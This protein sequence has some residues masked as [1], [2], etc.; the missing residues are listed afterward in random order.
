MKFFQSLKQR[1]T[2][3]DHK[4][5][6][7]PM[8]PPDP[9]PAELIVPEV[10]VAEL[11]SALAGGQPPLLLDVREPYEW[12]QVR[13]P[14]ALHMPMN[15]VPARL[16]ELPKAATII[17]FCAH[18]S[19]SYGVA[20]YLLENGYTARNLAGGITSWHRQGGA[21]QVGAVKQ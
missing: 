7:Q 16:H 18:G 9:E 1:L 6:S 12:N 17:V 5:L 15:D 8:P 19:R 11:Q 3:T 2:K 4:R 13:M 14:S 10:T 20:H 21:V